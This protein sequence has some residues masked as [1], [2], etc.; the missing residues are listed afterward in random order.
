MQVKYIIIGLIWGMIIN[1][2]FSNSGKVMPA[3]TWTISD[4]LLGVIIFGAL[5]ITGVLL[6][7]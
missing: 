3:Y 4:A 1:N 7:D 5:V 6:K 2:L